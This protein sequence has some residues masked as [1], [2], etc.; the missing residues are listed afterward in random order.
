MI[1]DRGSLAG[2]VAGRLSTLLPYLSCVG[3]VSSGQ[4]AGAGP[5]GPPGPYAGYRGLSIAYLPKNNLFEINANLGSYGI[6]TRTNV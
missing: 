1:A 2:T 4:V 5:A 3:P 6:H